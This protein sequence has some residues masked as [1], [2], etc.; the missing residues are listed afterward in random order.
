MRAMFGRR[1]SFYWK[2]LKLALVATCLPAI[3]IGLSVYYVGVHTIVRELNNAHRVQMAQTIQRL[4]DYLSHLENYCALLAFNPGIEPNVDQ[5]D[6]A[7]QYKETKKLYQTLMQMKGSNPLIQDVALY[8][9]GADRLISDQLGVREL[10]TA[11]DRR[12][13]ASLLNAD[14]LTLMSELQL[15]LL[16][17]AS[18]VVAVKLSAQPGSAPYAAFLIF[19]NQP[20]LD[21]LVVN[22]SPGSAAFLMDDTGRLVSS[23]RVEGGQAPSSLMKA[24]K[25]TVMQSGTAQGAFTYNWGGSS[26]SVSHQELS[27]L[28]NKWIYVSATPL[29]QITAPVTSLSAVIVVIGLL[30][31]AAA[32]VIAWVTS[33]GVYRPIQRLMN[34]FQLKDASD[35]IRSG[36]E[37]AFIENQWESQLK[38]QSFLETKLEQSLPTLREGFLLQWFQGRCGYMTE[39][40]VTGRLAQLGWSV[41]SCRFAFVVLQLRVPMQP[42]KPFSANDE[43]LIAYA[44]TN[45]VDELARTH[46]GPAQTIHLPDSTIGTMIVLPPDYMYEELRER[47]SRL[48]NEA[49][50]AISSLLRSEVTIAV[51]R[52]KESIL[53]VPE[54]LEEARKVLRYR[55][56]G[57]SG[58]ILDVHDLLLKGKEAAQSVQFPFA[59][60]KEIVHDLR[61]GL[62]EQAA[63]HLR[64]F[65][66]AL[67]TDS[68][69]ELW[70]QQGMMKLL[71]S[72]H[73]AVMKSGLNPQHVFNGEHMYDELLQQRDPEKLLEWFESK[74]IHPFVAELP[75]SYNAQMKQIVESVA[76]ELQRDYLSELSLESYADRYGI[77]IHKLSRSF[78]QITGEN[79][80]D[81]VTRLRLDKCKD[82]LV[83]TDLKIND[84]AEIVRYNPPYLV[85][86]FKKNEGLT[87]GQYREKHSG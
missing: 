16:P 45:I 64:Q 6:F 46:A 49:M 12:T 77:S 2:S 39:Q 75:R 80:I 30:G 69:T 73:E 10:Q 66:Q 85:R 1:G 44:A 58:Q 41:E 71:G 25:D 42:D 68:G 23:T 55:Q 43:Q 31:L 86:I 22:S 82:L 57:E 40:D 5:L 35:P 72:I 78:K 83:T 13:A 56:V 67:Q 15:D 19:I 27:R 24:M 8:L 87:P 59:L 65:M 28:G 33:N 17:A 79:F 20:A 51:S 53:E 61:M 7:R 18:K 32:C 21:R 50:S 48:A 11:N 54:L 9:R 29:S 52:I 37:I 81:F 38:Q 47:L 84:I 4:D 62:G 34:R 3:L 60:E 14:K 70:I 26:Y 74:A 36:N 63:V 76:E